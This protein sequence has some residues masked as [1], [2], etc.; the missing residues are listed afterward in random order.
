M[1]ASTFL[2]TPSELAE[3]Q[4]GSRLHLPQ[5]IAHHMKV[6]RIGIGE[7]VHLVDGQ[8]KRVVATLASSDSVDIESV[9]VESSPK[10]NITVAQALIKGD[11]LERALEMMTEVGADAFIPWAADHSVVKWTP[12]KASR[13]QA[14]WLNV[15]QAASEQSRRAFVPRIES[16]VNSK[17]LFAQFSHFDQVIVLEETQGIGL[18][19]EVSGSVLIVVGPEGGLSSGERELFATAHNCVSVTL[20]A[21]VFRSATAGVVALSHLYTRSGEWNL[22]PLPTVEG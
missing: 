21:N 16:L 10:L 3:V 12:E 11:R 1:S 14:K 5:S 20:G 8:G 17:E 2:V 22:L 19:A 7:R 4:V 13:N 15:V 18:T 6:A 9:N